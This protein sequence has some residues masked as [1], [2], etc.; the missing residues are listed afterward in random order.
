[1]KFFFF[2]QIDDINQLFS[3]KE[4]PYIIICCFKPVC[5]KLQRL[6]FERLQLFVDLWNTP[7][8]RVIE[9]EYI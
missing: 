1:M 2:N 7:F 4:V 6:R 3:I 5:F 9:T 8:W